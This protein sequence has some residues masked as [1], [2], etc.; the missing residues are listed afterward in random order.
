M[1]VF[2]KQ[3]I[4]IVAAVVFCSGPAFGE[5]H[6]DFFFKNAARYKDAVVKDILSADT[7]VL[8][9]KGGEEGETIRLIGLRA[10]ETPRKK[11]KDIKRDTFGFVIKEPVSP[12]ASI[13]ER[14]FEFVKDF[15]EGRH[16]RL[17]FDAQEKSEDYVTLAYVFLTDDN[18]FVNAEILRLG[19][20][21]LR[22]QPPN[23]KYAEELRAAY[24][25]ARAEKR[26]LQGEW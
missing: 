1:S 21:H 20:A 26:G 13:E 18:T 12:A 9:G 6:A 4:G 8:E 24:R 19:F 17:E 22:I 11:A 7:F 16:V 2:R 15:L 23:T 14:A 10:P 3:F 5:S 25:E